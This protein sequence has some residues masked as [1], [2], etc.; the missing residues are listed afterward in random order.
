VPRKRGSFP[1]IAS[2]GDATR[3]ASRA[4]PLAD[5][6]GNAEGAAGEVN[7]GDAHVE[8]RVATLNHRA[9]AGEFLELNRARRAGNLESPAGFPAIW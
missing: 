1:R 9:V 3:G 8:R 4:A 7:G 5:A 6:A 2:F